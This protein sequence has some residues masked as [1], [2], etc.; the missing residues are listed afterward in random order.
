MFTEKLGRSFGE[1]DM[2]VNEMGETKKIRGMVK[3]TLFTV[4]GIVM[5]INTTTLFSEG[6]YLYWTSD[7]TVHIYF[8]FYTVLDI[9]LTSSSSTAT[10]KTA[11]AT[12]I[13]YHHNC[14]CHSSY[15]LIR[16]ISFSFTITAVIILVEFKTNPAIISIIIMSCFIVYFMLSLYRYII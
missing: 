13:A 4:Q 16:S 2:C 9:L 1:R 6:W 5:K 3:G 14:S 12:A 10:T 8:F 15:T 7:Y 11:A